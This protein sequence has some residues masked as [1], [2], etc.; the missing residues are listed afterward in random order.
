MTERGSWGIFEGTVSPA[1]CPDAQG[2]F[3]GKL[4]CPYVCMDAV[5]ESGFVAV[6]GPRGSTR[7]ATHQR[8]STYD[9]ASTSLHKLNM[10]VEVFG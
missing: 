1:S 10:N 3:A 6:E 9:F 7:H 5:T 8:V 4:H 2:A